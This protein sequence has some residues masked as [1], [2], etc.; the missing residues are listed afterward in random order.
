MNVVYGELTDRIRGTVLD[1][2]RIVERV[3][4]TWARAQETLDDQDAYLDSV[5]LNLHGFYSGLERLFEIVA[6]QLDQAVP[7][8][9]TWHPDLLLQMARDLPEIRPAVISQENAAILDEFRRFRHLVR[10]VYTIN[11]VPSKM[12]RTVSVLPDL[13][14]KLRAE[15]SAF[16]DFTDDLGTL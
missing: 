8:G 1:L 13:W 11:I 9:E 4:R 12:N 16:A 6:R 2:D 7:A 10:N 5:A 14:T 15:L 3:T